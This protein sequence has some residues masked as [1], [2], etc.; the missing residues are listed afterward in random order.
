MVFFLKLSANVVYI[1]ILVIQVE[2][3]ESGAVDDAP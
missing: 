3:D 2:K 1:T